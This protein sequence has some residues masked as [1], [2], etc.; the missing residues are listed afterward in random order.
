V[1]IADD[2]AASPRGPRTRRAR[3]AGG[4]VLVLALATMPW[5]GR[6]V[7]AEL[8]FFRVRKIEIYGLHYL[9]ATD[10]KARLGVDT[11][12]SIWTDL[13]PLEERAAKHPQVA[14]ISIHRRL[15]GT[16]VVRVTEHLPVAL[17]PT[18]AGFEV[19][20]AR[21]VVLPVD[22]SGTRVNLPIIAQR[23][24]ALLRLLS[25]I[26]TAHP[27]IFERIS[28]A[29]RTGTEVRLLLADVTVVAMSDVTVQRLAD[30]LPVERD[31]AT[32]QLRAAELDLRYRER[33][34]ARLP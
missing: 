10:L 14:E 15:P 24:T 11:T 13:A 29:R 2:P 27:V 6:R 4:V 30:I 28:E 26:R 3:L 16:L 8:S 19:V 17:V 34:I 23:D 21:G 1:N 25:A 20:D 22:P 12:Q 31:L 9:A 18:R 32:K 33:V 7:L 5:W